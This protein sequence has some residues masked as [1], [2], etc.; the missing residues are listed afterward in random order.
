MVQYL[1]NDIKDVLNL[2]FRWTHNI[3]D[4][5]GQFISIVEYYVG[6]HT[7]LFS[8]GGVNSGSSE[9]EFGTILDCY[10]MIGV[11]YTF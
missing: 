6:D 11:E 1:Q 5:S 2:T 9:T 3:D 4:G 7:Q 10:C 8:I